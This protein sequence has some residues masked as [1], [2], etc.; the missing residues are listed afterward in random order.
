[1]V[2]S[3]TECNLQFVCYPS[4]YYS[5]CVRWVFKVYPTSLI[6]IP[7]YLN[8]LIAIFHASI[9]KEF[10]NVAFFTLFADEQHIAYV[11]NK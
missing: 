5:I 7:G 1:M 11:G 6:S 8:K 10:S 3:N 2:S 4:Y 9:I